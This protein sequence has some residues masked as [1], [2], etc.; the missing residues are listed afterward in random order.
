M[1]SS[2]ECGDNRVRLT[3]RG[4][5][6]VAAVAEFRRE[7]LAALQRTSSLVLDLSEAEEVDLA[8]LQLLFAASRQCASRM[9]KLELSDSQNGIVDQAVTRAGLR[10]SPDACFCRT[11]CFLCGGEHHDEEDN[12]YG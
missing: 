1:S 12:T 11:G 2:S 5:V 6:T 7:L 10:R 4:P 8:F 9:G 3:L